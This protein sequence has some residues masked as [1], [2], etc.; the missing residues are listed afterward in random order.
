[1]EPN[2]SSCSPQ[3]QLRKEQITLKLN[4]KIIL[5][6]FASLC[7]YSYIIFTIHARVILLIFKI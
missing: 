4:N 3:S 7:K 5:E 6:A 1:M 2:E